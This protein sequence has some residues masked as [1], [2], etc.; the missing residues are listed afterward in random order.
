MKLT[1]ARIDKFIYAGGWDVRW[2]DAVSGLGLRIYPSGKKAF[3]LSYRNADRRKRLFVLGRYGVNC[4]RRSKST[5]LA[6]VKMYHWGGVKLV[7]LV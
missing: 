6:G 2:D 5:P 3:V 7:Q 1:K 4:Q